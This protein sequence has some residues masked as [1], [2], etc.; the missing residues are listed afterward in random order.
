MKMSA[1]ELR[2]NL[3][4]V[5]DRVLETG[6]PVEIER[7]GRTVRLV[8]AEPPP[9]DDVLAKLRPHPDCVVGDPDELV[10]MDWSDQWKR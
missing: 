9:V 4:R 10:H 2:A 1:T 3:Y 8:P 6:Q 7:R 5:L